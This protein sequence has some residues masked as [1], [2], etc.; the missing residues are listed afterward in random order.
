MDNIKNIILGIAVTLA[1]GFGTLFFS[2]T[3]SPTVG[4]VS[5]PDIQSN[6]LRVGGLTHWYQ[7]SNSLL[8]ATSTVCSIATPASTSTLVF[9][10]FKVT[11]YTATT[12]TGVI[13][14]AA[15]RTAST[16]V[17]TSGAVTQNAYSYIVATNMAST[18]STIAPSQ[19]IN[20]SMYTDGTANTPVGSCSAEFIT[21]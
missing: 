7:Q 3:G 15:T 16:T 19:Y 20:F 9:A 6:W 18:T 12:T 4:A 13:A 14:V 21:P 11:S 17:L 10:G 5:S 8:S 2:A 1:F